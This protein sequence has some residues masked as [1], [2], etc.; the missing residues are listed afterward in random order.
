MTS[1]TLNVSSLA[2]T[3]VPGFSTL[4]YFVAYSAKTNV[5]LKS[6]ERG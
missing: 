6:D 4:R 1:V 3:P 2:V 5:E